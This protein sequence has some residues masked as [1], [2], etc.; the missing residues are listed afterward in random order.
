MDNVHGWK[1]MNIDATIK[2]MFQ[3]YKQKPALFAGLVLLVNIPYYLLVTYVMM[4]YFPI[5]L[6]FI[7]NI[8]L[9]ILVG[10][11]TLGGMIYAADNVTQGK[12]VKI[13]ECYQFALGK[14][15]QYVVLFFRILW[16]TWAWVLILILLLF[17]VTNAA[18][19]SMGM[20]SSLVS[21][22]TAYAQLISP[23]DGPA[24]IDMAAFEGLEG[25]EDFDF[26]AYEDFDYTGSMDLGAMRGYGSPTVAPN[27]GAMLMG[28]GILNLIL[29]LAGL[30]VLIIVIIRSVRVVFAYYSLFSGE[31]T[32]SK[33]ALE[34][35]IKL[36]KDNWW[37]IVGYSAMATLVMMLVIIAL[38][39]VVGI[40]TAIIGNLHVMLILN[41]VVQSI[42]FPLPILFC[43]TFYHNMKKV[44]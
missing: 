1:S 42:A 24:E 14:V 36:A 39:I 18:F 6:Y 11:L 29:G 19:M 12:E 22:D 4:P 2:K 7:L 32:D 35:S 31:H 13:M 16:Y 38:G 27:I 15:W 8:V 41:A 37:T 28:G 17:A 9:G 30:V 3:L 23:S 25:F 40:L 21:T 33:A 20:N 10:V 44:S 26:E 5:W 43:Y 34:E